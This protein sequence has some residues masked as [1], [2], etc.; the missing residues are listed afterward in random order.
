MDL[1]DGVTLR[2]GNDMLT[3]E[4]TQKIYHAG[5]TNMDVFGHSYGGC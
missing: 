5:V 1:S 2:Y 4:N 3:A